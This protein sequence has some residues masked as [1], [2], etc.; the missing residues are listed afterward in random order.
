MPDDLNAKLSAIEQSGKARFGETDWN[1]SM[2][3]LRKVVPAGIPPAEMA[4]IAGNS[5]PAGLLMNLGRHA[6]MQ[7]ASDG[8]KEAEAAYTKIRHAER[9][10]HAEYKGRVW[11]QE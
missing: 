6:L 10:R 8:D 3:A 11:Q 9:K 7:Q 4:Q 5:D 2:E 1:V